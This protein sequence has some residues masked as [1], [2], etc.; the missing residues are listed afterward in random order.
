MRLI[1]G[2]WPD[3]AA[4][5]FRRPRLTPQD[6]HRVFYEECALRGTEALVFRDG[7]F[8]KDFTIW[9]NV[10]DRLRQSRFVT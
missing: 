6:L 7:E 5:L 10:V 2:K 9:Q 4:R 1:T 8:P 3:W